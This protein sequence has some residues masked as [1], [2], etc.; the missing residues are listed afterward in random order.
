MSYQ[1]DHSVHGQDIQYKEQAI[2][3]LRICIKQPSWLKKRHNKAKYLLSQSDLEWHKNFRRKNN[4]GMKID[5]PY[6]LFWEFPITD[7]TLHCVRITDQT[8]WGQDI[9]VITTF[10]CRVYSEM[11]PV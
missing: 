3:Q 10:L 11:Y 2:V 4:K 1:Q 5:N 9:V 6:I 8:A 7:F